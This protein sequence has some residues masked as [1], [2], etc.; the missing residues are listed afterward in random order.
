IS[1]GGSG[2]AGGGR[3]SDPGH[4][5]AKDIAKML[6]DRSKY[7]ADGRT[8]KRE[9]AEGRVRMGDSVEKSSTPQSETYKFP[10]A[11]EWK[12]LS[13]R[14]SS[15]AKM[16]AKERAIMEG[17]EKS[18]KVDLDKMGF[19]DAL[20][21][22][23]KI[24]GLPIVV[25]KKALEQLGHT[26]DS[27][28]TI[29]M[30]GVSARSVLKKLAGDLDMTYVIKDESVLLTSRAVASRMTVTRTYYLGDL[31]GIVDARLDP[32]TSQLLMQERVNALLLMITNKVDR[33]SWNTNN[34]DSVG[35]IAFYAPTMS[36]IVTQTAEFH[37]KYFSK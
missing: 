15:K 6:S 26:Y 27:P 31:V 32:I 9:V 22:L 12:R 13:E 3:V 14:R 24:T 35:K 23:R 4:D 1:S 21:H 19:Q 33:E 5:R 16:T 36:L 25:D 18:T 37:F 11:E 7:L 28:V 20:D 34:P 30:D 2:S 17:L 8:S 10:P 29:R